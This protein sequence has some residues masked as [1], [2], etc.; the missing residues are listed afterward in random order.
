MPERER[1]S[2]PNAMREGEDTMSGDRQQ[3]AASVTRRC[4]LGGLAAAPLV[5]GL[6]HIARAL[7]AQTLKFWHV[8]APGGG[9][10]RQSKWFED[11]VASWNASH[12]PKVELV[13][14]PHDAYIGATLLPSAFAAG[15]GPDLFLI[16]AGDFLRYYNDGVLLELTP[17]MDQAAR[18]DFFPGVVASQMVNNRLYGL[19]LEV[20]PMAMFYSVE[21]FDKAGLSE[22]D[23][24]RTW[25][26]LLTL[27]NK[28]TTPERF[29]VLFETMPGHYQ[30]FSWYPWLW[31]GGG[32]IV[33][34]DG[35]SAFNSPAAVQALKF[36]RD[37]INSGAAARQPRGGGGWDSVRNIGSGYCA[38]QN[39]GAWAISQLREGAPK[40]KYG[41][42]K[43]PA[44]PGGKAV[45]IAGGWAFAANARGANPKAAGEFCAWALGAMKPDSVARGVDWCAKASS[46]MPPR[47]SV[48]AAG[49]SAFASG[50]LKVF[51]EQIYPRARAEPRLPP[52][53]NKAIS[54]AI[55]SCQLGGVDPQDAAAAAS[56]EIDGFLA[57]Y[58]GAPIL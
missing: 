19:P 56:R 52:P 25:D 13:Y 15:A 41:V 12:E 58:R 37:A 55:Q 1:A 30:N 50:L 31:Q 51:A 2:P 39:I 40:F 38:M 42:F 49:K 54:D 3:A 9:E 4:A 44:P 17:F 14:V 29:G 6:P 36:W 10:A 26:E 11:M 20:A 45:T 57:G 16:S 48:L 35:K 7:A 18:D 32:E 33:S 53:V 43:L 28:L 47:K 27:A 22:K 5:G 34:R 8:Y 24:P 46:A 23:I 21:A